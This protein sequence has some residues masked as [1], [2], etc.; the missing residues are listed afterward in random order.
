MGAPAADGAYAQWPIFVLANNVDASKVRIK[1][2]SFVD[3]EA[4]LTQGKVDA[5]TGFW[6]SSL[7]NLTAQ[8]VAIDDISVMLMS[9]HGLDLYGNA[10]I[11]SPSIMKSNPSVVAA[12]VRATIRGFHDTIASPETAIKSVIKRNAAANEQIEI[13]RLKMAIA[14]NYI[15]REVLLNGLG[16]VD[17]ARLERAIRQIAAVSRLTSTPRPLDIFAKEFLPAKELRTLGR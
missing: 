9:D 12:F 8:G 14:R 16:D 15:T 5:I 10:V 1:D 7:L 3:R 4:M 2:V 17:E 11:A 6:F 13:D